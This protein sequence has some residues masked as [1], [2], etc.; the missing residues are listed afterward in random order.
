MVR[1]QFFSQHLVVRGAGGR[2][3]RVG[4]GREGGSSRQAVGR[5]PRDHPPT[6]SFPLPPH[7]GRGTPPP[8]RLP[9]TSRRPGVGW[10]GTSVV[11]GERPGGRVV[12][13]RWRPRP[14]RLLSSRGGP[15][16][17]PTRREFAP[18]PSS[19][20]AVP[21]ETL[22]PGR[23][24]QTPRSGR[25]RQTPP[26]PLPALLPA[27]A[28]RPAPRTAPPRQQLLVGPPLDHL[29][30][31]EH[32]DQV[33]PPHGRDP[34]G[35]EKYGPPDEHRRQIAQ[36][37]L[38]G[39][40]VH[41]RQAVVQ[42]QDPRLPKQRSRQR[43]PLLLAARKRDP[44]LPD[45]R[46]Q[47]LRE[48]LRGPPRARPSPPPRSIS[49]RLASGRPRAMFSRTVVENRKLSWGTMPIA[50][51]SSAERQP[52]DRDA[53]DEHRLRRRID[54]PRDERQQRR[55]ARPGPPDQRHRRAGRRVEPDPP[56]DGLRLLAIGERQ[57]A[58]R[59][60]A[61]DRVDHRGRPPGPRWPARCPG[62]SECARATPSRAGS[63]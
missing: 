17:T 35:D 15:T 11:R 36:D 2:P 33:R 4:S 28:A 50:P 26:T 40:R 30:P 41:R 52:L 18:Q 10:G 48:A 21:S 34:V 44:P 59:H 19:S 9:Q 16:R 12:E 60:V 47:P 55:L 8:T 6:P 49:S 45:Q 31:L 22:P 7:G 53:V 42:D 24:R 61:P 13:G 54:Q 43:H 20:P 3:V 56:E 46:L 29:A 63:G 25:S 32:Q 23:S 62:S 51:R 39:A 38:L 14:R 27:S 57:V 37:L 5:N 58:H 1:G